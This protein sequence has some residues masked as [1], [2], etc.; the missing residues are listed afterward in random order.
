MTNFEY[1]K[2]FDV[3]SSLIDEV[4]YNANDNTVVLDVNNE[5][6]RYSNV[7]LQAVED[8][9]NGKGYNGSVGAHYNSLFKKTYG[10]GEDLG[11]WY[12]VDG[13]KVPVQNDWSGT[14]VPKAMTTNEARVDN[15]LPTVEYS[16]QP[17]ADFKSDAEAVRST[18]FFTIY[19]TGDK[20][21]EYK[22]NKDEVAEAVAEV[23]DHV[24]KIGAHGKVL[25][26][27]FE[28]SE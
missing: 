7:T 26:V 20:V 4:F 2:T 13:I 23:N 11:G 12:V 8:L 16:L 5:M 25:K 15:N 14:A 9:V 6:Y 3:D 19:G 28:F 24:S 18:V 22:S 1:T 21:F 27:V 10:P 17:L